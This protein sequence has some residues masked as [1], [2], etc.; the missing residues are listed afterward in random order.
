MKPGGDGIIARVTALLVLL[1]QSG[2][3]WRSDYD[4]ARA[5]AREKGRRVVLHFFM[6]GRP[7]C[8]AME[9]DTFAQ[10]DVARRI[11]E[12]F[13]GV[14]LDVEARPELFEA[15]IGSRGV[16]ATCVLDADGDV[17]SELRGYAGPQVFLRFLEKAEQG[18]AAVKAAREALAAAPD[19]PARLY[20]LGEAYRAA[21]SPRRADE[22]YEKA[23]AAKGAGP[24]V[25]ASHE[26][27]ARLRVMRGR[28]L[29]ARSHLE[30]A[31]RLDPDATATAADRLL[32]TEGLILAVE[33][34]HAEAAAVL[35][36]ALRRFP[37]GE[38][39]DHVLFSLGFVLHQANQDK[40]AL[41]ALE[42]AARRFPQSAW[43]PAVKE[44][45]DHIKNPQP[46]HTH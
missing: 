24:A 18:Y 38:E 10:A 25:A 33:R 17:I 8:R 30:A 34:R 44:Q 27:L 31:R 12:R 5:E 28:N 29:E 22:C 3:D 15:A 46:D 45:I 43:L 11:R 16:L 19:D 36:E 39:A 14:R 41:E 6:T 21:D 7:I 9:E 20:A 23:I 4:A 40:A 2:I 42:D 13:V 1:A 32:L 37:S 26:R 35:R